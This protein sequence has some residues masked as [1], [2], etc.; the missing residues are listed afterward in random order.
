MFNNPEIKNLFAKSGYRIHPIGA[1]ASNQNGPVEQ[2]HRSI[3][4]TIRALL[5]G[6]GIDTKFWPYA[7]YHALSLHNA[8]PT[9]ASDRSP[10][11]RATNIIEDLSNLCTFGCRVWVCP[12]GKRP[13]KLVPHSRKG[14]FLGYV[15]YTT[16]NILW[17]DPKTDRVKI[18]THVRFNEGYNDIP[19]TQIPPNIVHLH[20]T[21]DGGVYALR[22]SAF[23]PIKSM[24]T[25]SLFNSI[26]LLLHTLC[27]S[28]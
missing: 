24:F 11:T 19:T 5:T 23:P 20:R 15:P 10:L 12:P 17:Y 9:R 16:R 3:V 8:L 28:P 13:V 4:D 21:E 26:S 14:V 7:F 18:A 22:T 6:S 2:G 27:T 25:S 1:D